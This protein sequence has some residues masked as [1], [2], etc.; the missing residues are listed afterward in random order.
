MLDSY[1]TS[2][3][4]L[5]TFTLNEHGLYRV[6]SQDYSYMAVGDPNILIGSE[7]ALQ[8]VITGKATHSQLT[9]KLAS[10]FSLYLILKYSQLPCTLI[11]MSRSLKAFF[12][13]TAQTAL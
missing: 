1:N 10:L 11:I 9:Q 12:Y 5:H 8:Y 3:L 13:R 6:K 4:L 2:S 7:Q